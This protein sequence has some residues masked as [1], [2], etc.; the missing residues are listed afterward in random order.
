[1]CS[2]LTHWGRVMDICVGNLTIIGS[3][4]GLSPCRRQAI[5]WTNAGIL[6]IG[7][8]GTNRKSYIFIQENAFENVVWKIAAIL[9]RPQ[10]VKTTGLCW[11]TIGIKP[12]H[13]S[14]ISSG[15]YPTMH[16]FLTKM[17]ACVHISVPKWCIVRYGT[18]HCGICGGTVLIHASPAADKSTTPEH[19]ISKL[20]ASFMEY[21]LSLWRHH[22]EIFS[23]LLATCVGNSP[24]TGEF[25]T[26][27][28]MGRSFDIFFDLRLNRRLSKQSWG[29]W[30]E[31]LIN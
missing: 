28:P 13:I 11:R 4:F 8:S 20:C 12:S 14:H 30:F 17:C 10:C 16:H 22:M 7:P 25:H 15:K 21:I 27:R 5:I 18:V 26:Q 1:M 6:L 9:P 24:V 29:W 19:N 2:A 3:D 23:V 31:T